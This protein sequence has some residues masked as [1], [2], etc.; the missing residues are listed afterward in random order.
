MNLPQRIMSVFPPDAILRIDDVRDRIREATD[1]P[2]ERESVRAV[3]FRL[4]KAGSLRRIQ[5]GRS[6]AMV[7][8][9]LPECEATPEPL[10]M[11]DW[12]ALVLAGF[13]LQLQPHERRSTDQSASDDRKSSRCFFEPRIVGGKSST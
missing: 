3:L 10:T 5:R 7:R 6:S 8:Y 13:S 2:Y 12:A 4:F 1:K 9:R 11:R